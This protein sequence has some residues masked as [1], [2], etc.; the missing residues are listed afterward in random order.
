MSRTT[1]EGERRVMLEVRLLVDERRGPSP[2]PEWMAR[3]WQRWLEPHV[4]TTLQVM[5]CPRSRE[6]LVA[7]WRDGLGYRQAY[8]FPGCVVL[9]TAHT[10]IPL[11]RALED[12]AFGRPANPAS[13]LQ[14]ELLT[15]E[16]AAAVLTTLVERSHQALADTIEQ[17]RATWQR[18]LWQGDETEKERERREGAV[19][20]EERGAF[21]QGIVDKL[22][23]G[24][25]PPTMQRLVD[26][27]QRGAQAMLPPELSVAD[28]PEPEGP[29]VLARDPR[30]RPTLMEHAS[31]TLDVSHL[32]SEQVDALLAAWERLRERPPVGNILVA[33]TEREALHELLR[34]GAQ[35]VADGPPSALAEE[36]LEQVRCMLASEAG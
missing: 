28:G 19:P 20:L 14:P 6:E 33:G 22:S 13:L 17:E 30:G 3:L 24:R 4:S 31:V 23:G 32:R 34:R 21:L 16:Q 5:P 35:L 15:F 26:G 25:P 11:A 8:R 1:D 18:A 9:P 7:T 27:F 10:V 2:D 36:W 12:L 29:R